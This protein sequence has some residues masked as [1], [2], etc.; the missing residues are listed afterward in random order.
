MIIFNPEFVSAWHPQTPWHTKSRAEMRVNM[1]KML[2]ASHGN[3]ASGM[4][5]SLELILG[6]QEHAEILCAYVDGEDDVAPR[7]KDFME[8]MRPEES[9]IVCTDLFG[10]SINNEFMKYLDRPNMR[11]ISGMSLPMVIAAASAMDSAESALEVE[12]EIKAA[13]SD[14]VHFCSDIELNG[15]Q[16]EDEEF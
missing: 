8:E 12:Q 9:W 5:S 4:L 3:L 16:G 2:L 1:V 10:G 14:M 6:K 7:V 15:Q 13:V 11:L